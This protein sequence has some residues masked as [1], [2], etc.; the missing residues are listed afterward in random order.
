M[1]EM[2]EDYKNGLEE[3]AAKNGIHIDVKSVLDVALYMDQPGHPNQVSGARPEN[4]VDCKMAVMTMTLCTN[5]T[6]SGSVG[7]ILLETVRAAAATDVL[8]VE[9]AWNSIVVAFAPNTSRTTDTSVAQLLQL[10]RVV[11]SKV[12]RLHI[13]SAYAGVR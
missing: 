2:V 5:S 4:F 3:R 6:E 9:E 8:V 1:I 12:H 13:K 11:A 10:S 7:G